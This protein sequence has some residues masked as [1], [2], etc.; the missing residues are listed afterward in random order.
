MKR[1][2][3]LL[4]ACLMLCGC[5]L[6]EQEVA[7]PGERFALQLPDDMQYNMQGRS[8]VPQFQFAY[9]NKKLEM[10]VFAYYSE[11]KTLAEM[12]DMLRKDDVKPEI[13]KIAGVELLSYS[14]TDESGSTMCTAFSM[15]DGDQVIEILFWYAEDSAAKQAEGIMNTL[16]AR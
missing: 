4:L 7:L 11:G 10:D 14:M 9:F 15:L 8:D 12:R 1:L 2:A 6:A 3:V 5:A 13:R 16:A